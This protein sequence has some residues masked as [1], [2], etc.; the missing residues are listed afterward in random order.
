MDGKKIGQSKAIERYLAADFGM[1]GGSS[2]EAA[3]VDM[4]G[5]TIRDIKESWA[6]ASTHP[7]VLAAL[8]VHEEAYQ[9]AKDVKEEEKAA[10]AWQKGACLVYAFAE[11]TCACTGSAPAALFMTSDFA[12]TCIS[13]H[14]GLEATRV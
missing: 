14:V 13:W 6:Q 8:Y 3:Q 11:A 7:S 12:S 2:V 4:L 9:K 10:A 1:M 5:E